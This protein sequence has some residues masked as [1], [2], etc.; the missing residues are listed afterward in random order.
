MLIFLF[1]NMH[2]HCSVYILMKEKNFIKRSSCIEPITLMNIFSQQEWVTLHCFEVFYPTFLNC[3][4][5]LA[6]LVKNKAS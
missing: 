6:F 1:E 5:I 2:H 3:F 4:N